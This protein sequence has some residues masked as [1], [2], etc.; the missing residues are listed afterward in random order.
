MRLLGQSKLQRATPYDVIE[1]DGVQAERYPVEY[2]KA[3]N[4]GFL[5]L[6]K[7]GVFTERVYAG[8]KYRPLRVGQVWWIG[9][10][11]GNNSAALLL[12]DTD[13]LRPPD[14]PAEL[15][16]FATTELIKENGHYL[17]PV[18][19]AVSVV[20]CSTDPDCPGED[21]SRLVSADMVGIASKATRKPSMTWLLIAI[22]ALVVIAIIA[23]A[24][25]G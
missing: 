5:F 17:A 10:N 4:E 1:S 18:E 23:Y 16:W 2:V 8:R 7:R 13:I 24:M 6:Y 15:P 20:G 11:R 3:F 14:L 22:G 12:D 19:N 25:R 9:K 21:L